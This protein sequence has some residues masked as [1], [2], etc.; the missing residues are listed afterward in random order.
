M[1][2]VLDVG[3]NNGSWGLDIAKRHPHI[4]VFGFEPTPQLVETI[5]GKVRDLGITNYEVVPV[6]VSDQAGTVR[7]NVAGQAD[8][9]CSSLLPFN[10]G[11][12]KTWPGRTDFKVTDV[13]DVECIRLDTFV[14]ARG[15]SSIEFLHVDTQGTDLKVMA[16]LGDFL[17]LVKRG[18]IET[19]TSRFVSLYKG[20][21]TLEDVV[22]FFL[23]HGFEIEK[24]TP[25]D[26]HFNEANVLFRR[27][28][29]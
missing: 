5:R 4:Q 8:W 11:L 29:V 22:L 14:E 1:Q 26:V 21:H 27:R 16:S 17:R 19:S 9:G 20:Q 15:I 12:D 25:N 28:S 10:E 2:A 23:K 6:A 24:L 13:I 18:E 3:A 7:F